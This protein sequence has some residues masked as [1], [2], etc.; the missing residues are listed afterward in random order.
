M[1]SSPKLTYNRVM[2]KI[3]SVVLPTYNE[4]DNLDKF[5]SLLLDQEKALPGW[6]MEIVIADSDSPDGTGELA[7]KLAAK[8]SQIHYLKVG[9]GLGVGLIEG[10]RYAIKNIKP[11]ILAQMDA[12]G[13]VEVDVIQRLIKGIE[14]GYDFVQG[15]R[16]VKGGE[17]KLSFSRRFFSAGM[18]WASRII[19]GPF[20]LKEFANS[21]RA[22]TPELF[23]KI[24]FDRMPWQ[25]KTFVIQPSFTNEAI[26]AGA[27]YKEVPLIFKNRAEGYSK[28]KVVNYTYDVITYSIAARLYKLGFKFDFFRFSHKLKTLLKFSIV[29]FSG[30]FVDFVIYKLLINMVHLAP[31]NAKMFSTEFGIIN[32]F[33]L[34]NFWT[35]KYRKTTTN[36]YQ[37]FG[38]YNFVSVGGL[39]IAV[40][41]IQLLHSVY[42]D[43][44]VVLLNKRIALNTLYFFATIPPAMAW[45]FTVNHFVTWRNKG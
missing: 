34:N 36:V 43:G 11:D 13:Q 45:N 24:N 10:H 23:K 27:R 41:T 38:I 21:A 22:F 28:N 7:K 9:P 32:N 31:A 40:L 6:R 8:N 5:V 37:R 19:M 44:S 4:K 20:D 42:G 14:E 26:M 18:S 12:D 30:T 33:L 35:F 16:F 17:N 2:T 25:E 1:P 3:V 29:G 39:V 15:S